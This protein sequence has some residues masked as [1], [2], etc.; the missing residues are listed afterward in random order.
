MKP[1]VFEGAEPEARELT[2]ELRGREP[3]EVELIDLR[4]P[5]NAPEMRALQERLPSS[6]ALEATEIWTV[7]ERI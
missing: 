7:H 3:V 4:G 1:F 2:L 5:S 6:T